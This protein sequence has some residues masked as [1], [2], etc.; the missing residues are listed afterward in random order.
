MSRREYL[1]TWRA[2]NREKIR[3][4]RLANP[5]KFRES[6]KRRYDADPSKRKSIVAGSRARRLR[7]PIRHRAMKYGIEPAAL[8]A[9]LTAGCAICGA[10]PEVDK[11]AVLHV[12]H[13]HRTGRVRGVLCAGC[14][15]GLGHF[16]DDPRLLAKAGA[17]L[18]RAA[19]EHAA[20]GPLPPRKKRSVAGEPR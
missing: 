5:E 15:L 20:L 6:A 11:T 1:R 8:D 14:N 10:N 17:Y 2:K 16:C 9:M 12:D 13:D 18:L 3:A 4:Y 19:G 7:D